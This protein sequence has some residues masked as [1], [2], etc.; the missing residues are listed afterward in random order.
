MA[1]LSSFSSPSVC[2]A[3][4]LAAQSSALVSDV[5]EFS[6]MNTASFPI[7]FRQLAETI[8]A[9]PLVN[10][11]LPVIAF[12]TLKDTSPLSAT[13]RATLGLMGHQFNI[14]T[15]LMPNGKKTHIRADYYAVPAPGCSSR[16]SILLDDDYGRL[17]TDS[18]VLSRVAVPADPKQKRDALTLD[19]LASLLK[20]ADNR[21]G[22]SP[23]DV[24]GRNCF[25]LT[26][27]LFYSVARRFSPAW[28]AEGAELAP[29]GPLERFLRGGCGVLETAVAC[30]TP[31]EAARFWARSVGTAIRGIQAFFTRDASD[32][33]MMHDQ[34]LDV[35]IE[36]WKKDAREK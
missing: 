30:G 15:V 21:L 16:L 20:V 4:S 33:L 1:S 10:R 35:W 12:E 11:S 7:S 25:W 31:D 9:Q 13:V 23:Y 19:T 6:M 14:A 27:L 29:R 28:L 36:E 32:R 22:S 17:T 2:T 34:E 3:L 8:L 26:D 5:L 24:F 18:Q